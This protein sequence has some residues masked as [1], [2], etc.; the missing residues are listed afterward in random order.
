[1]TWRS[2]GGLKSSEKTITILG[3]EI[4]GGHRR[5]NRKGDK[6]STY[7]LCNIWKRRS[8]GPNVGG[9]SVR[10]RNGAPSRKGCVVHGQMTKASNK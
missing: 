1:M 6:I 5:R 10:S 9:V 8:E 7:F 3:H 2:F 4:D